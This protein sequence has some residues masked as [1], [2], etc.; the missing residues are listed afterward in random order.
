MAL[1]DSIKDPNTGKIK[2]PILISLVGAGGLVLFLV[3]KGSGSG[4]TTSAGQSSPLTP[5]LTGLQTA[6]QGLA[7]NGGAGGQGGGSG[8]TPSIDPPPSTV[9]DTTGG[10]TGGGTVPQAI[11]TLAVTPVAQGLSSPT[12]NTQPSVPQVPGSSGSGGGGGGGTGQVIHPIAQSPTVYGGLASPAGT[13]GVISTTSTGLPNVVVSA[14]G[15]KKIVNS[16]T[17][18]ATAKPKLGPPA[19][20]PVYHAP[21]PK[22]TPATAKSTKGGTK[23]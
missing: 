21:A 9:I 12:I 5:D 11:G 16:T 20:T 8:T 22:A 3:M 13:G 6:L 14:T 4:T 19:P 10:Y 18:I 15:A 7:A 23:L 1:L 2:T 17:K